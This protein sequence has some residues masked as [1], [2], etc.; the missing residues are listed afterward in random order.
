[1]KFFVIGGAG[2]IGSHF[3]KEASRQGHQCYVYDNLSAGHRESIA[4][5]QEFIKGDVRRAV[6]LAN[7]LDAIKPDAVFHYAAN[8]LVAESVE[9]PA[10]YYDNNVI[11]TKTLLE[12]LMRRKEKPTLV[13]S[14]S[15]AVYGTP[16][17]LPIE[18]STLLRPMSPYGRT[19]LICEFMIDDFCRAYK[20]KAL[21][22]RYFNACGA[23]LSGEIGESHSPET[24]LIANILLKTKNGESVSIFGNNYPTKDGTCVRDYIH[25]TD[26]AD[27][28]MKAAIFLQNQEDGYFHAVNLGSGI[29]YSNLQ[30][31]EEVEHVTGVNVKYQFVDA[32][33]G[34]P[35]ELYAVNNKATDMLGFNPQHSNLRNIIKTAWA[36]HQNPRY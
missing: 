24:H 9:K 19:K 14:S 33:D 16:K 31:L 18:E 23:D 8:A 6:P 2:Y 35:A 25:V 32:R 34:D 20:L 26:L 15:C 36:W 4:D 29:G 12:V 1:M 5:C 22:L 28:H 30:I 11:G 10:L 3:V 13:F 7:A 21:A 27:A 17:S